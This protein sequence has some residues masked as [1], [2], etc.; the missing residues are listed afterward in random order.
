MRRA[1]S[2][3][4]KGVDHRDQDHDPRFRGLR[5]VRRRQVEQ[6]A[7][8]SQRRAST[9]RWRASPSRWR[10]GA[11]MKKKKK[12]VRIR[13]F[14]S[15][16]WLNTGF[17]KVAGRRD[18]ATTS[19]RGPLVI[20]CDSGNNGGHHS[21]ACAAGRRPGFV[22]VRTCVDSEGFWPAQFCVR[23]CADTVLCRS[24]KVGPTSMSGGRDVGGGPAETVG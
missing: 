23:L 4:F 14:S 21:N 3:P 6:S 17:L 15:L 24:P 18:T 20:L 9:P 10:V 2:G 19:G 13:H 5:V 11:A 1:P 22:R 8:Q 16:V 7:V 12:K